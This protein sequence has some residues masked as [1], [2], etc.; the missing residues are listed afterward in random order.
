MSSVDHYAL[1]MSSVDHYAMTMSPVDHYA[2]EM[3]PVDHYVMAMSPVDHY[4]MA[5]S[6]VAHYLDP[7]LVSV[8]EPQPEVAPVD[9]GYVHGRDHDWRGSTWY[10]E[11]GAE[12]RSLVALVERVKMFVED[13][14]RLLVAVWF[15]V[16]AVLYLYI[17]SRTFG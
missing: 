15:E 13:V 14:C 17:F 1:T 12:L 16:I 11:T 4:A 7:G 2:M 6:P 5:M 3:S 10:P 9:P 8:Q